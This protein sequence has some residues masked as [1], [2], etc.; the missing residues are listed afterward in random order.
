MKQRTKTVFVGGILALVL[1]G[2]VFGILFFR[3]DFAVSPF[4]AGADAYSRGDFEEAMQQWRPLGEKG[5]ATAQTDI[6]TMYSLAACRTRGAY[7]R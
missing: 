3:Y 6:G 1:L 5:D 4:K 2:V 7:D